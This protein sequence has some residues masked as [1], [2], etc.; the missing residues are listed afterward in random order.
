MKQENDVTDPSD[1]PFIP[2]VD[3]SKP[4]V[5]VDSSMD[6]PTLETKRNISIALG[7]ISEQTRARMGFS[8]NDMLQECTWNGR[9][10]TLA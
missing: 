7:N 2:E 4:W 10:C 3:L 8:L 6:S 5:N 1:E 9:K